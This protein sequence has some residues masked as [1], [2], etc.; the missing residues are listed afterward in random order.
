MPLSL[1]AAVELL[2]TRGSWPA[3]CGSVRASPPATCFGKLL[4]APGPHLPS[5]AYSDEA[6]GQSGRRFPLGVNDSSS[7][8]DGGCACAR[9][10]S[11]VRRT[12]VGDGPAVRRDRRRGGGMAPPWV[13]SSRLQWPAEVSHPSGEGGEVDAGAAS[14]CFCLAASSCL[15]RYEGSV[16]T[17]D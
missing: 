1:S 8:G 13:G 12:P 10:A 11:L 5:S 7:C 16:A 17:L 4:P 6:G 14:S 9:A 3:A 15:P 2:L